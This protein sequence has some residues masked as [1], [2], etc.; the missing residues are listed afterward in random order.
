MKHLAL[1]LLLLFA[2][3]ML[4]AQ[5][6]ERKAEKKQKRTERKERKLEKKDIRQQEGRFL[7]LGMGGSANYTVDTRMAQNHYDGMGAYALL[8]YQHEKPKG[9]YDFKIGSFT[10]NS[11]NNAA[12]RASMDNLRYDLQ[13][14]Y[15]RNM[16]TSGTKWQWRLGGSADFTYNGRINFNL[17]NDAF[18]HDGIASLGIASSL[19]RDLR[20]IKRD[21]HFRAKAS[22][23]LFTY[24]NRLPEYSL[25]GW[26]GTS[27][28][29]KP[30]G[31]FNRVSTGFSLFKPFHKHTDNGFQLSYNWD[32]YG[33]NDSEIHRV[34]VGNHQLGL[35]MLIKI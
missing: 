27:S 33:F 8:A 16:K 21:W 34:R 24:I 1:T 18:G 2:A 28:A 7:V 4:V 14:S 32:F 15:L 29:F 19:S 17:G 35:A 20:L 3:S 5:K 26:G 30:I 10:Y 6:P 13:F 23:P 22:L 12:E 9:F 11:L 25:S 31:G